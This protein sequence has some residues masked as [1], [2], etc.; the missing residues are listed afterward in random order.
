MLVS[1]AGVIGLTAWLETKGLGKAAVWPI[2]YA[3]AAAL[4]VVGIL[5]VLVA[6]G[7]LDRAAL[8]SV[9]RKIIAHGLRTQS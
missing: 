3:V 9:V 7:D 8:P 5:A 1:G 6:R 4:V 2:A